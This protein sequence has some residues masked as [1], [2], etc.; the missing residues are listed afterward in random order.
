MIP[1]IGIVKN[2]NWKIFVNWKMK[3]NLKIDLADET[4]NRR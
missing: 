3:V 2:K 1:N 4:E